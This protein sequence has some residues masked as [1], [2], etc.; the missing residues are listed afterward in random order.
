VV[1][2]QKSLDSTWYSGVGPPQIDPPRPYHNGLIEYSV[3]L[4]SKG[5]IKL[6]IRYPTDH[7]DGYDRE[8]KDIHE[9]PHPEPSPYEIGMA[10][11]S[12]RESRFDYEASIHV[13]VVGY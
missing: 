8:G 2:I 9:S 13:E 7:R 10:S 5:V 3:P 4:E 6:T 12:I 1:C 11:L